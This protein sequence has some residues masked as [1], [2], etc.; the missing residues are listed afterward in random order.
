MATAT[1]FNNFAGAPGTWVVDPTAGKGNFTTIQAAV[2]AAS[3]GDSV[4]IRPG[5]YTENITLK[6]G[7]DLVGFGSEGTTPSVTIL[8][9]CT[10][11]ASG[12]ISFSG[13]RFQTNSDYCISNTSNGQL[14][15][16][17][18]YIFCNNNVAIQNS[19]SAGVISLKN[20]KGVINATLIYYF[21]N[22]GSIQFINCFM[23][24]NL[25]TTASTSTGA[26]TIYNSSIVGPISTSGNGYVQCYNSQV[27]SNAGGTPL[28]IAGTV[29]ASYVFNS[30][31]WNFAGAA[32]ITIDAG[33]TLNIYESIVDGSAVNVVTGL[34][35]LNY[36]GITFPQGSGLTVSNQTPVAFPVTEG[37]TG[38]STLTNHGVL[39]GA[40]TSAITQ[41]TVGTNGQVLLGSTG[42][43]PVFAT[44]TSTGG[45]I[46]YTT[47][48]GSLNLE[49][50]GSGG[51]WVE[52]T[53]ATRALLVNQS[54]IGNRGTAQTFTLPTTAAQGSVIRIV[55]VGAGAITIAQNASEQIRLG[56]AITTAGVGGSLTT[57]SVGDSIAI[58]CYVADTTWVAISSIGTWVIV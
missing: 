16:E 17:S 26:V 53:G 54:V 46:S 3:S 30:L 10:H 1:N 52:E 35:T 40:A 9:K 43:D 33:S 18:C 12:L 48:A 32:P 36:G 41:L 19:N 13:I 38:R 37:G 25:T 8:G 47:G 56:S 5:T 44:L 27:I 6:A 45:T 42:A 55:Q 2:T 57:T 14:Y 24:N 58:V 51:A 7:V 4:F 11:S 22:T 15:L 31:I 21:T 28:Q 29:T 34:G 50:A 20:C 49:A 39:V 23:G